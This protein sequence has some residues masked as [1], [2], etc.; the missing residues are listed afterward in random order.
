MPILQCC[1]PKY[2]ASQ[3]AEMQYRLLMFRGL[4]P[5]GDMRASLF[6][7]MFGRMVKDQREKRLDPYPNKYTVAVQPPQ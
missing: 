4:Q 5:Q 3:I 1:F 6:L 7:F 2:A